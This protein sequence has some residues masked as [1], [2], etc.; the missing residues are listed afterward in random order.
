MSLLLMVLQ[1]LNFPH[2]GQLFTS[3]AA[4][5]SRDSTCK[6]KYEKL[7]LNQESK[8]WD[9]DQSHWSPQQH[10]RKMYLIPD[11][12]MAWPSSWRDI[13]GTQFI[14]QCPSLWQWKHFP[15]V[16]FSLCLFL[17]TFLFGPSFFFLENLEDE[18]IVR[19]LS[20]LLPSIWA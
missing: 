13:L 20:C 6:H 9:N 3:Q 10:I 14:F 17:E 11:S 8:R 15:L 12:Q 18:A 4:Y 1:E 16:P 2:R 7:Q 19:T 5:S